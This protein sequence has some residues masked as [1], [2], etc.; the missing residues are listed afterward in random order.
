[1]PMTKKQRSTAAKKAAATRK[2]N[3][4]KSGAKEV[5]RELGNFKR[6][7][8]RVA[9]DVKSAGSAAKKTAETTARRA[10]TELGHRS[11]R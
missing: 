9:D 1:M 2:R 5:Q 3:Q 11:G 4:A 6:A 10:N 8:E 7:G